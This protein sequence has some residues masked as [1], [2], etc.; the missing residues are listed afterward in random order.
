MPA[1]QTQSRRDNRKVQV[2]QVGVQDV[3]IGLANPRSSTVATC[4]H[5]F[6]A[7]TYPALCDSAWQ[8]GWGWGWGF[9][10]LQSLC[11]SCHWGTLVGEKA[12]DII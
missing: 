3:S 9:T 1:A 7:T 8:W 5:H 12:G 11:A 2:P 4:L 6:H 10:Q